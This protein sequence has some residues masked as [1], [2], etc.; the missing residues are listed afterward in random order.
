MRWAILSYFF[1]TPKFNYQNKTNNILFFTW[2]EFPEVKNL[3]VV[4]GVTV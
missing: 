4:L 3:G 2:G 1:K